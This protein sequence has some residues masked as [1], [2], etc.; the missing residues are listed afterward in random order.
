MNFLCQFLMLHHSLYFYHELLNEFFSKADKIEAV[1]SEEPSSTIITSNN[2]SF[3]N[4][5]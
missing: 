2:F 4:G 3:K 1:L 5:F